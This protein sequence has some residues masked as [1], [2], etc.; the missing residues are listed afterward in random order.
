MV[1]CPRSGTT[2]LQE[3]LDT[4]SQIAIAPETHFMRLFWQKKDVYGNLYEDENYYKLIADIIALPEFTEMELNQDKFR[5]LALEKNR[6]YGSLFNL[7]LEEFAVLKKAQIVGE[8]TPHHLRYIE[9]IY[10]FF[11][12][13]LFINIIRDPRAVVNSW[14]KVYWST[15]SIIGDARIWHKDMN[16][17][18]HLPIQIK[19][20]VLTIYYEKL[21]LESEKTL[22]NICDFIGVEFE[23]RM[24]N[25]YQRNT[26][27]VNVEREPW[28]A[29]AKQPLNPELINR[30]QSELSAS[31]ILD[32]ETLVWND[33]IRIGY[34]LNSNLFKLLFRLS[35]LF[36]S[37][38]RSQIKQQIKTLINKK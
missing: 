35:K 12:S 13:A 15:G 32:I 4:H 33:M 3:M 7:L 1:G 26:S 28:K 17:I 30:W 6:D 14:R 21:V 22:Q 23:P 36:L 8:K 37:Q 10:K 27:S 25:F 16:I 2:L 31:M 11:P 29:N 5:Q 34:K 18:N 20:S 9:P 19:P 24:L 38:K